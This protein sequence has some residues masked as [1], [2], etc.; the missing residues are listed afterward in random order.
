MT[1]KSLEHM[2]CSWAQTAEVLGDKWSMM[3]IRCGYFGISTFSEFL[4][5]L[6]ISKTV[7]THRLEHLVAHNIFERQ[8]SRTGGT[9]MV[10]KLTEKGRDLFPAIVA[11]GQ[12]ADKWVFAKTGAP[13]IIVDRENRRP[14]RQVEVY[15]EKGHAL[16]LSDVTFSAG[17]GA[18]STTKK[19]VKQVSEVEPSGPKKR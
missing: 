8:P 6:D 13:A 11:F 1:R 9:R 7:L 14:V 15:S 12:W 16:A 18:S 17:P 5:E 10:Y 2:N 4:S 3:I 19:I